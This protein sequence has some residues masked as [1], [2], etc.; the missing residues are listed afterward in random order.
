MFCVML[1]LPCPPEI[2]GALYIAQ[3][4]VFRYGDTVSHKVLKHCRKQLFRQCVDC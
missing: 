4:N 3:A 2:M 1:V